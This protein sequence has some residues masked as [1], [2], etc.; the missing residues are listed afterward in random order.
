MPKHRTRTNVS[1]LGPPRSLLLGAV[2][3]RG[4]GIA[5]VTSNWFEEL[6]YIRVLA[7]E[8]ETDVG[9]GVH[10]SHAEPDIPARLARSSRHTQ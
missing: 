7:K 1:L 10:L 2:T 5:K 9:R 8:R 3:M 6:R 4:C